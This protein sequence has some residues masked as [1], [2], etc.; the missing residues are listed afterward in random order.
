MI[1]VQTCALPIYIVR[2]SSIFPPACKVIPKH[3]GLSEIK[4][5]EVIFCVVSENS[6]NEP[7]R[8]IAASVGLAIPADKKAHGYLSEHHKFGQ[9]EH[10]AGD[11]AED[12]AA[13]MLATI[14]GVNFDP[15]MSWDE[16]REIWKISGKIVKTRNI[17]QSA[18][19]DKRGRWTT[20][21][22]AAVLL[23]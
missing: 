19:G 5:G 22:A 9:T 17:T 2:V 18:Q 21:V 8:L 20:V 23:A 12:L 14:Q 4:P 15:D 10:E 3:K 6:T 13:E 11:Y 1:G 16:K 7:H